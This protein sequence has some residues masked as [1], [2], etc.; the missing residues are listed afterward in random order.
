MSNHD[1]LCPA[2]FLDTPL[3]IVPVEPCRCT[4]IA[5]VRADE[6]EVLAP[7]VPVARDDL[8]NELR[9]NVEALRDK[10]QCMVDRAPDGK[11]S[12]YDRAHVL[13]LNDVLELIDGCDA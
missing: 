7:E 9:A 13:A 12:G 8:R 11:L 4:F 2:T 3:G 6:R 5:K 1:P 10:W